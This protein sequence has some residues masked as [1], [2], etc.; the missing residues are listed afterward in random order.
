[1]FKV[2]NRKILRGMIQSLKSIRGQT[3]GARDSTGLMKNMLA[4]MGINL[5]G[6]NPDEM[7][8]SLEDQ[9]KGEGESEKFIQARDMVSRFL[10]ARE[11]NKPKT[12]GEVIDTVADFLDACGRPQLADM[13][14]TASAM[15]EDTEIG[16]AHV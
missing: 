16:R 3:S 1:M 2:P 13:L 9:C 8:K 15:L 14:T 11:G 7:L 6:D 4:Q 12:T 10:E 5:K